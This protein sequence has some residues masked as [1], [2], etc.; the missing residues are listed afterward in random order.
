[1]PQIFKNGDNWIKNATK[2]LKMLQSNFKM[3]PK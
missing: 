1:M 2:S 3:P